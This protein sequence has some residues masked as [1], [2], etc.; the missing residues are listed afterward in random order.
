MTGSPTSE[1]APWETQRL[2]AWRRRTDGPLAVLAVGSLPL[3]LLEIE[4]TALAWMDRV[5]ID[6]TNVV[7]LVAF[8]VD[9]VV[10]LAVA[11][12]GHRRA[13]VRAE[14]LRLL[15]LLAQA[16]SVLPGLAGFGALRAVR[17]VAAVRL[18]ATVARLAMIGGLA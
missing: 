3:L 2:L 8:V 9:Y 11:R 5:L 4:Y 7:V 12:P 15:V 1:V 18:M 14:W 6:A 17:G 16:I 10:E 13:F